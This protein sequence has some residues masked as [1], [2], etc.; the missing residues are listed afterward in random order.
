M[1]K[2]FEKI[3]KDYKSKLESDF[4]LCGWVTSLNSFIFKNFH[5]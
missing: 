1:I 2:E 4:L 5:I 3:A